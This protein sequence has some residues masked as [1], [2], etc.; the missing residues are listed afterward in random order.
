MHGL[1]RQLLGQTGKG[2]G[3]ADGRIVIGAG[4]KRDLAGKNIKARILEYTP[5]IAALRIP[6]YSQ[7]PRPIDQQLGAGQSG[8]EERQ[9]R[10]VK[11]VEKI[12]KRS[13]L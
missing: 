1:R 11:I 8:F 7:P 9:F 3:R 4:R 13:K 2:I 10:L 5:V 12:R 6:A